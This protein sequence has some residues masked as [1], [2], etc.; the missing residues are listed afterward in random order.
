M[1]APSVLVVGLGL[2][3]ASFALAV[4][5]SGRASE[6]LGFDAQSESIDIAADRGIIDR[7][8]RLVELSLIH[9]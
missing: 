4:R 7:G 9:I 6:V 8:G 5:R 2:I 1:S 3:G